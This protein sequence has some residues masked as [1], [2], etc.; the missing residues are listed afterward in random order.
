MGR[1]GKVRERHPVRVE[2]PA[3]AAVPGLPDVPA[4]P[5]P[6]AARF[7]LSFCVLGLFL[8]VCAM[9]LTFRF[10]MSP[11]NARFLGIGDTW[12]YY[13][14]VLSFMD[15]TIHEDGEL[16]LWNPLYFCGQPHAA[17]PQ[18][19]V[20]YPPNLLRSL[21]TFHPTPLRTH[22]G[23][24]LMV[25]VQVVVAGIGALLLARRHGYSYGAAL[26]AAFAFPFSGA[27]V[28]RAIG[29]WIFLNST[30][31]LP[32]AL[33]CAHALVHGHALSKRIAAAAWT[34]LLYG[35]CILGGVPSLVF[36]GG[37]L[38][39]AYWL[40][41]TLGA[42]TSGTRS[43]G[44]AIS[45]PPK[46]GLLEWTK[47]LLLGGLLFG[48]AMAVSALVAAPL[49]LPLGEFARQTGRSGAAAGLEDI[50][51]L[52]Y[53]WQLVKTLVFYEGHSS[54]EGI[55]GGGAAVV[56][57]AVLALLLKPR[58]NG[59][60][61]AVLFGL[62][63]DLSVSQ[64]I[65][66]GR[67]VRVAAPFISN[68]PGRGMAVGCLP[69]AMLAGWGLDAVLQSSGTM[70]RK[71]AASA[72]AAAVG[73][74]VL[75][76]L[77]FAVPPGNQQH[78][79]A[80]AVA[81]PAAAL[82]TA[83]LGLWLR[84]HLIAGMVAAMLV[85]GEIL[86]WNGLLLPAMMK[87]EMLY[88][89]PLA[90]LASRKEIPQANRRTADPKPNTRLYD[91]QPIMNGYDPLHLLTTRNA[92]TPVNVP[93]DKFMAR[94]ITK[95]EPTAM[96][97]RGN[98]FLKRRFWLAREYCASPLPKHERLY[99]STRVAF[100]PGVQGLPV[101][102]VA[103]DQIPET[104]LSNKQEEKN[105]LKDGRPLLIRREMMKDPNVT[106]T[107]GETVTGGRHA[108]LFLTAT[109]Q[110]SAK[111]VPVF[112][113]EVGGT[114]EFG[115]QHEADL[116]K[117]QPQTF[118]FPMPDNTKSQVLLRV[119][120]AE[121]ASEM[122]IT[123]ASVATDGDDENDRIK[124][125]GQSANQ[126]DVHLADLPAP[127]VL[128]FVDSYYPGW[129]AT[130]NGREAPILPANNAFKAVVVPAGSSDVRFTFSSTRATLGIVLGC[131]AVL[132]VVMAVVSSACLNRER[133]TAM[134]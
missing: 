94:D 47:A 77:V 133:K 123:G 37:L 98:L 28:A 90:A 56:S 21:L 122:L 31:W 92:I 15:H 27:L 40:L 66:F 124:I 113:D 58:W 91:L 93:P 95:S 5:A 22:A 48:G 83:L 121:S 110:G 24:A 82:A 80:I 33:L 120:F 42:V 16:P 119:D 30:C 36:M 99:P 73:G 1:R 114:F 134:P 9:V 76:T 131:M 125:V 17:N 62:V 107:I 26:L 59:L 45:L 106:A 97:Q 61:W 49:L 103:M 128:L 60:R 38:L 116:K 100:L 109:G 46:H 75:A 86:A 8:I 85:L 39:G 126:V 50:A 129:K 44:P 117:D 67:L 41:E 20:F 13:G 115:V 118:E 35:F 71:L 32:W 4:A 2:A 89:G 34:G 18:S 108:S 104:G 43:N 57:F 112:K 29:H 7:D 6:Q 55:R 12:T 87:P 74:A 84:E 65:L 88:Q 51:P 68:N 102:A 19:F 63:L 127:R 54:Y 132:L 105:L 101:P 79:P 96:S 14:P 78:V 72:L 130:V 111:F 25:L 70:R 64:P 81:L 52:S 3:D 69:L 11:A 10:A 53:G 23:I